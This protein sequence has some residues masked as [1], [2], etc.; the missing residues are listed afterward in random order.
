MQL[1]ECPAGMNLTTG[2]RFHGGARSGVV[3]DTVLVPFDGSPLAERAVE[4]AVTHHPDA[5]I[6]VLYVIDPVRAV[7]DVEAGGLPAASEWAEE[8]ERG[9]DDCCDAARAIA[10]EH[11]GTVETAVE[12]GKPERAILAYVDD[13]G[14]D[15]VVMGSHG[16]SGLD[17]LLLGSVTETV[18]RRSPVPVTVVR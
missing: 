14:V 13:H 4:H 15:H 5:D 2:K 9:A 7:Y 16:R 8:A 1:T 12:R 10:E 17:R 18:M 6:T 3:T 11:G